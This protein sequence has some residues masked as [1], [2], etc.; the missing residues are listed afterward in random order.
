LLSPGAARKVHIQVF[1]NVEND[2]PLV[3]R[4]CMGLRIP[5]RR[6]GGRP[7]LPD[8][9]GRS[10]RIFKGFPGCYYCI[11]SENVQKGID[12]PLPNPKFHVKED[13][14]FRVG[15]VLMTYIATKK[16]R[17]LEQEKCKRLRGK[18]VPLQRF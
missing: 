7:Q 18:S 12:A 4:T 13:Q 1:T 16:A 15:S 14:L 9:R 10:W 2:V 5:G 17:Y 8:G 3:A 11:G 6:K